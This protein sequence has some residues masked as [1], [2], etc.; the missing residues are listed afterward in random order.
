[1]AAVDID[2]VAEFSR[3]LV[4]NYNI[5]ILYIRMAEV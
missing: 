1:L 4:A 3:R 5:L 2:A